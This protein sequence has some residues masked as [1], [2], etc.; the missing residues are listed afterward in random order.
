VHDVKDGTGLFLTDTKH[1]C[2]LDIDTQTASA[3]AEKLGARHEE[4]LKVIAQLEARLANKA[5]VSGAPKAVVHQTKE[6]LKEARVYA[7]KLIA[8]QKRFKTSG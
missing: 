7:D 6:Q 1:K 5:Y 2:W 3:Y 4:Q 8:E